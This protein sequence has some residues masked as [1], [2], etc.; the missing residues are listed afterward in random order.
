MGPRLFAALVFWLLARTAIAS[1]L[2]IAVISDLNGSYGSTDYDPRVTQ[3]IEKIIDLKPDLVISAGDMVAGQRRP[4]LSE[5]EVRAMWQGFHTTV[6]DPLAAAGIPLVVTPGNHDASGYDGFQMERQI[7]EEEWADRK[8]DLA[9]LPGGHWPLNYAFDLGGVRFAS[10]NATEVGRMDE[11]QQRWLADTMGGAG[12]TRILFSHLPLWPFAVGRETEVIGDPVVAELF[13]SLGV[14]L[15]ISGHHHAYYPGAS[16]GIAFVSMAC[17][18][19]GP[20]ALIGTDTASEPGF[21]LF[22]ITDAGKITVR[23][24]E[25]GAFAHTVD[26]T[27]LP[28]AIETPVSHLT[29][30]DLAGLPD[31]STATTP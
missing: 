14:K 17:L 29:R 31:V 22:D 8:P 16:D 28:P 27:R 3:A 15:H 7:Y 5:A 23:A 2:H 4:L 26:V 19:A 6:S 1:T 13:T 11:A 25:G 20:R 21:A 9:F 24:L 18:G 10:L 30:L 12:P